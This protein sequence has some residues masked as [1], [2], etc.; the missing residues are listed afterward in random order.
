MSDRLPAAPP[1]Y[2]PE[3]EP[4]WT[5]AAEGRLVLPRC[6]ACGHHIWY[7]RD[8]CPVCGHGSVTW[9]ELS[10]DAT[11]YAVTVLHKAMGPWSA[12]APFAVA[13]VELAEG[14]RILANIVTTHAQ[15]VHIGDQV[16]ATFV[17]IAD[18][19]A[20]APRQAILRFV[21]R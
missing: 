14:P 18:Q 21:P 8:W 7:P 17:P 1:P 20:D 6:D 19:A 15:Q 16:R 12:A 5:A 3:A 9:T 11:V 2:N 10:G 13:Y 4:F